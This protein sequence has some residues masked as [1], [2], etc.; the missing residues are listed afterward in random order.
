MANLGS[1]KTLADGNIQIHMASVCVERGRAQ[2]GDLLNF[3]PGCTHVIAGKSFEC[4]YVL[5]LDTWITLSLV[6][7]GCNLDYPLGQHKSF[8]PASKSC[9]CATRHNWVIKGNIYPQRMDVPTVQWM[10]NVHTTY[11]P[12]YMD[13]SWPLCTGPW[14]RCKGWILLAFAG[15]CRVWVGWGKRQVELFWGRGSRTVISYNIFN[16]VQNNEIRWETFYIQFSR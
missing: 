3:L 11:I 13:V 4:S 12:Q 2:L 14:D 5:W 1:G 7:S 15:Q 9:N 16:F 8:A 6:N 10:Y